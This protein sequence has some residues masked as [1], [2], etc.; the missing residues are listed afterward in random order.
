MDH[1]TTHNWTLLMLAGAVVSLLAWP[2]TSDAQTVT[3]QA[4]AVRAS[5]LGTM[6][7]LADSGTLGGTSDARDASGLT[8]SIPSLLSGE[9]LHATTI[10]YPD[11][12]DS[13]ASLTNLA[14]TVAGTGISADF[15]MSRAFAVL[16]GSS[17]GLTDIA[18]LS[19]AGVPVF[20]SGDLN[21]TLSFGVL[22]VVLNEQIPSAD[23]LTVNALHVRTIDGLTDVVIGSATAGVS[24]S[25]SDSGGGGILPPL[26]LP[27]LF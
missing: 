13:E 6:T 27:S 7:T 19:I 20:P 2:G 18:G 23:G 21:Q 3:G 25:G 1:K 12:V 24:S 15:V 26:P 16:G 10:G 14:M 11:E 17:T 9:A 4:S 22:S 5:V 8:G